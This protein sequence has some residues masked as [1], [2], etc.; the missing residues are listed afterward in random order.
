MNIMLKHQC[1]PTARNLQ[2]PE[3]WTMPANAVPQCVQEGVR[4]CLHSLGQSSPFS[5]QSP[6]PPEYPRPSWH[7]KGKH[8]SGPTSQNT[9]CTRLS[10]NI[11]LRAEKSNEEQMST[12]SAVCAQHS[13]RLTLA[14][15]LH[16]GC[17]WETLLPPCVD[18]HSISIVR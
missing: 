5:V 12:V 9:K 13:V 2:V 6:E 14:K 10:C 3:A 7:G 8:L 17:L 11:C 18:I 15:H 4:L 16:V 1:T